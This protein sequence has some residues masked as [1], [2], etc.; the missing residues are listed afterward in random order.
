MESVKKSEV[1]RRAYTSV[2]ETQY[3]RSQPA[4]RITPV[5][6]LWI[7]NGFLVGVIDMAKGI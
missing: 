1:E 5:D 3:L 6:V 2:V 4:E 7:S